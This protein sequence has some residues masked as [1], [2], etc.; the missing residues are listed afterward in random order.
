M[1]EAEEIGARQ[2]LTLHRA[3]VFRLTARRKLD[4]PV[5][6][7]AYSLGL[8]DYFDDHHVKRLLDFVYEILAPGDQMILGNLHPRTTFRRTFGGFF[9]RRGPDRPGR[10]LSDVH[11]RRIPPEL[12]AARS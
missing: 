1:S 8:S 7:F 2:S 3:N 10:N 9:G 5:I 6:D 4:I 11:G 12:T